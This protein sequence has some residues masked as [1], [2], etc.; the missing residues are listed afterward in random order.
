MLRVRR[1]VHVYDWQR[2]ALPF[3]LRPAVVTGGSKA[4]AKG[5]RMR[6]T[7]AT[8]MQVSWV[9]KLVGSMFVA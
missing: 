7:A 5:Y 9:L 1:R 6:E 3:S 4:E 2:F 8:G